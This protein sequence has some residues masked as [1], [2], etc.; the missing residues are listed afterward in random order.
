MLPPRILVTG[1]NG[2]VGQALTRA[3]ARWPGADVLATGRGPAAAHDRGGYARLDVLDGDAVDRAFQDFAPDVV[4]HAA[5]LAQVEPC[6]A[7]REACWALNVD[8][9][10]TMASACHRHGARLVLPSTDFVFDGKG[11]P[12]AED[13]R[14]APINAYGRSK[15]AAEN[16]MKASRL[17][18]WA[19]ARTTMVFGAPA[20]P[21]PRLDFVR[22]L[23]RELSAGRPVRVPADQLRTPTYDDDLADGI[24]RIVRFKRTGVFHVSGREQLSVL[25]FARRVAEAFDLDIGLISPATTEDLHPG[26]PRPLHAGLL[27]LRAESELGYHPRPL[28]VALGAVRDRL[29]LGVSEA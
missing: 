17:L 9:V 27:I 3:A 6:E 7:D 8:A 20:G 28:D 26:A 2:L 11:G 29:G 5:G 12:Y 19:V 21:E 15:L 16:A 23:V 4:L 10:G 18:D 1:A 25:D 22:W 13:D 14:P 24:L